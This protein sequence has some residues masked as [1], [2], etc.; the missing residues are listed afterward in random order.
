[1][2]IR[3]TTEEFIEKARIVHGNKYDYSLVEYKN[4]NTKV[5]IICLTCKNIFEQITISHIN[6]GAECPVCAHVAQTISRIKT[7]DK[8]ISEAIILHGNRYD[9]SKV[10]Y[11]GAHK[12]V[13]IICSKCN[14]E[15]LQSPANHLSNKGC[16]RCAVGVSKS[17]IE[18]L[19][20][21]FIPLEFRQVRIKIGN[22]PYF[23]DAY[24]RHSNTVYEFYGDFWHGNPKKYKPNAI[25]KKVGE[26]FGKL[27]EKLLN[28]EMKLKNAGYK[29][30]SIWELD[31]KQRV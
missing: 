31:W 27:Y 16:A 14:V 28:K 20:S 18:W 1:M 5:K 25:N 12:K 7:S 23:V 9:Y 13:I 11:I 30:I 8:F 22:R 17:E 10:K 21:L 26:T 29:I 3:L 24:D 6:H 4:N 15:F 2:A 19:D